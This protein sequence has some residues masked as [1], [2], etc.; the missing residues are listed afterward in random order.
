MAGCLVASMVPFVLGTLV[1]AGCAIAALARND[2]R[3]AFMLGVGGLMLATVPALAYAV[4]ALL[5]H[6]GRENRTR[7][8]LREAAP[9]KPWRWRED[10]AHGRAE[11]AIPRIGRVA[12]WAF[13]LTWNGFML[14]F[15]GALA[16]GGTDPGETWIAVA[17]LGL[18]QV[19]GAFLFLQAYNT[20]S[21][22]WKF[23]RSTF[24]LGAQPFVSGERVFGWVRA[25][26]AV[27]EAGDFR[28]SLECTE[29]ADRGT[30]GADRVRWRDETTV[31]R[32]DV[33][34]EAHEVQVPVSMAL[35]ADQPTTRDEG[36][37]RIAWR[38]T[39]RAS[40]TGVDYEAVFEVPVFPAAG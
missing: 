35:P 19:A 4:N 25:P 2:L 40:V 6:Q 13:A 38:L 20:S 34:H 14:V 16:L 36:K 12:M 7:A 3:S 15:W 17:A 26:S 11:H 24:E 8:R 10:W 29:L 28:L 27:S 18:F 23:G 31:A 5:R 1:C 33:R 22:H 32:A 9:G 30:E 21:A 39:V 37:D